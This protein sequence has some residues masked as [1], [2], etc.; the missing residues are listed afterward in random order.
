MK[1]G[2]L[3][4]KEQFDKL[5]ETGFLDKILDTSFDGFTYTDENG[6]IT[7][8][9]KTYSELTGLPE[10]FILGNSIHELVKQGYPIS[11]M[12][13]EVFKT[14][15]TKSEVIRYSDK[16]E[17]EIMVTLVPV[18]DAEG[19]FR[20]IV[21]NLRDLTELM[22]LRRQMEITHLEYKQELRKQEEANQAL[23]QRILELLVETGDAEAVAKSK[24]MRDLVELAY[25][26]CHVHST[27]LIT[28]ESG[29]GKDVFC[30]LVHK[31]SGG[32][33]PYIKIS[34]GAIPENLL[35]SELFGYE[36]GAFTGAGKSG[37]PGIFE[38]AGNGIVFLDEIGEMPLQLQV[39]LL[40]VLQDR[41]FFR[42]G[43]TKEQ[44]MNARVIA[45]T[46]R[47]LKEEV[48]NGN[49]RGDLYYRLNVIPVYIPPLRER[50][51]DILP[52]T[53]HVL[54][55][56]NRENGTEKTLG[57]EL[58]GIL[59]AYDWPGNV[60]ELNNVIERMY[61]LSRNNV[62][63]TENLPEELCSLA[64]DTGLL[65]AGNQG[66]TLKEKME[67]VEARL[68][69]RSLRADAT[70]QEIAGRLGINI[71]TLERKIGRYNLP[72]RYKKQE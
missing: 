27:V 36:P 55:R 26:I 49:F 9:N 62:L 65:L 72:R 35:E 46:N 52:L 8:I 2:F 42:I 11:R 22:K 69:L 56:L 43:G 48:A 44:P 67:A 32:D 21:G 37:K 13:L 14:R 12:C 28:G 7:Y 34:C 51:E 61:V 40:T 50:R 53:D 23:W 16:S 17:R 5:L 39:K 33:A 25:R 1:G 19:V 66:R 4:K 38:L 70:L 64:E 10:E 6:Y 15:K 29:A 20:G 57:V 54:A 59:T 18:Y 31:F 71:S 60:R 68:I 58:Q 30:K 3:I 24:Q 45:A 63:D 47:N 41:T